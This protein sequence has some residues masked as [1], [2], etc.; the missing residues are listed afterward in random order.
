MKSNE[1]ELLEKLI[2]KVDN[3]L[4]KLPQSSS[5]EET[6]LDIPDTATWLKVSPRTLQNYRDQ[7]LLP[8]SQIGAK[9]YFRL[10]DLQKF[11]LKNY[12]RSNEISERVSQFKLNSHNGR[13][14]S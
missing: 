9:I 5:P 3:L 2:T 10:D 14:Q 8:Y 7:G 6:W 12:H 11:L 4:L 1:I 13:K